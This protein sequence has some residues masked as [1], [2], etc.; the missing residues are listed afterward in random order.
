[1]LSLFKRNQRAAAP[2]SPEERAASQTDESWA[3]LS[4]GLSGPLSAAAAEELAAVA[5]CITLISDSL[6]SV[7]ALLYS[8]RPDGVKTELE[9]P[10]WLR[11]PNYWQSWPELVAFLVRQV[12]LHGAAY[13][14]VVEDKAGAVYELRPWPSTWVSMTVHNGRAKYAITDSEG[15]YGA[16]GRQWRLLGDEMLVLSDAQ[17]VPCRAV[18]RLQRARSVFTHAQAAEE[19]SAGLLA[20]GARPSGVLTTAG[21]LDP[22][23]RRNLAAQLKSS[24]TGRQAGGVLLLDQGKDFK[25]LSLSSSADQQLLESRRLST[26]QICSVFG[27]PPVM[28]GVV[29]KANYSNSVALQQAFC[30]WTLLPWARKIEAAFNASVV[31]ASQRLE[32]DLS[33]LMRA[34]YAARWTANKAAV[35]AGI[36]SVNDVRELEGFNPVE[37]GDVPRTFNQ[38]GTEV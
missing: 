14:Q 33:G 24:F 26:E 38:A 17:N 28:I 3:A 11:Q 7:P 16:A 25:S 32:L 8:V 35:D 5:A 19:A 15:M 9:P 18:S 10:L 20:N 29:D 22:E 1:M 37:G 23:S 27:V 31:S 36:L 34:D 12:L 6:A 30:T 21:K 2:S 13:C 4:S